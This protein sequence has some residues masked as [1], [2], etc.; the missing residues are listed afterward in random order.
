MPIPLN[1]GKYLFF[2]HDLCVARN[3]YL[4]TYEYRYTYQETEDGDTWIWR[5]EYERYP[6]P[7]YQYPLAH[8]HVNCTPSF[9]DGPKEFDKLHIPCG[10][11]TVET[12]ARHLIVEHKIQPNSS[13]W[14]EI[15]AENEKTFSEIQKLRFQPKT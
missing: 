10:R 13:R 5:F 1:N 3:K 4:A 6:E 7:G 2:E 11:I 15:L 9:Y 14:Q 8:L 12:L